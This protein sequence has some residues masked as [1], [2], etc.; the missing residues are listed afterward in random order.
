MH[1]YLEKPCTVHCEGCNFPVFSA[2]TAV[3]PNLS[4]LTEAQRAGGGLKDLTGMQA[5][6]MLLQG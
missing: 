6:T 4:G 2:A 3:V 1:K 5:L